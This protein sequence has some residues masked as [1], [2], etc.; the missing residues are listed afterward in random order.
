M[1]QGG[2]QIKESVSQ[3]SSAR[4][5]RR[6]ASASSTVTTSPK[7]RQRL[8]Y[9]LAWLIIKFIGALPR[10]LARAAGI[11]LGW[12]IYLLHIRLRRVGMRNLELAFPDKRRHQR[13]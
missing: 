3:E 2:Q 7:M 12:T 1:G 8:E 4:F 13:T 10:P 9:A 5:F 11:S 6:D